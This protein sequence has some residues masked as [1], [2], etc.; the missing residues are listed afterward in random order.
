MIT[1][2]IYLFNVDNTKHKCNIQKGNNIE[3]KYE[4]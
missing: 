3:Y 2:F 1:Q 4:K